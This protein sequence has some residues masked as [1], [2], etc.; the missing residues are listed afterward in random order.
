MKISDST[1]E[2]SVYGTYSGNDGEIYFADLENKPVKGDEVL[3]YCILQNF[4]G[5]KEVKNARLIS[6]KSNAGNFDSSAYTEMSISDAREATEGTMV[7]VDGVVARITY[8]NG[9][10]PSGFI[11]VDEGASIYVYETPGVSGCD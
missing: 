11:L 8:A 7:K 2:I 4:N 5:T 10:K 6:F 1:G 9:M 3:L